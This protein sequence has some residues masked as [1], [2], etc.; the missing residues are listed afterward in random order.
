[1]QRIY[2]NAWQPRYAILSLSEVSITQDHAACTSAADKCGVIPP[3]FELRG[4]L[5]TTIFPKLSTTAIFVLE[6]TCAKLELLCAPTRPQ[7][8]TI[9]H[10]V[11]LI[12]LYLH[13]H[14]CDCLMSRLLL[15]QQSDTSKLIAYR[16]QNELHGVQVMG[17]SG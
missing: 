6:S 4:P 15:G 7:Y 1:M 17:A 9:A 16:S 12:S 5:A 2:L 11:P 3:P 14:R 8:L 13:H 10:R